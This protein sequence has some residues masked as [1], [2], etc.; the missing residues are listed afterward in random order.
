MTDNIS[1]TGQTVYWC[2][3]HFKQF[4]SDESIID[5]DFIWDIIH[6]ATVRKCECSPCSNKATWVI[7]DVHNTRNE[8]T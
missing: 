1:Y 7:N 2:T 4:I 6:R 8:N 5:T 3:D